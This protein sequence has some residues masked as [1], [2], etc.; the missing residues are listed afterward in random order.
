MFDILDELSSQRAQ[1]GTERPNHRAEL[2]KI[3]KSPERP[4]TPPPSDQSDRGTAHR[5][6]PASPDGMHTP[7]R[8][9]M[10]VSTPTGNRSPIPMNLDTPRRCPESRAPRRSR[11]RRNRIAYSPRPLGMP[12]TNRMVVK[13]HLVIRGMTGLLHLP[14]KNVHTNLEIDIQ[15]QESGA[16]NVR[17]LITACRQKA[18]RIPSLR[19][20]FQIFRDTDLAGW[21]LRYRPIQSSPTK[22]TRTWTTITEERPVSMFH[23]LFQA[24]AHHT[25]TDVVVT[26]SLRAQTRTKEETQQ[27][28]EETYKDPSTVQTG[29]QQS[30]APSL[31]SFGTPA[32]L[33]GYPMMIPGIHN[34]FTPHLFGTMPIPT[35]QTQGE[36]TTSFT[37]LREKLRGKLTTTPSLQS[38]TSTSTCPSDSS[39]QTPSGTSPMDSQED[40]NPQGTNP[41]TSPSPRTR[42]APSQQSWL[43]NGIHGNAP[44]T[45][46][47]NWIPTTATGS[48]PTHHLPTTMETGNLR[49]SALTG[50]TA[51]GT[52]GHYPYH[53]LQWGNR[54]TTIM[55]HQ[56]AFPPPTLTRLD[57]QGQANPGHEDT[58]F[59]PFL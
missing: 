23:P 35:S 47:T 57:N 34:P 52:T 40:S 25:M 43:F 56:F 27:Q 1:S 11:A 38:C 2:D 30:Q 46:W 7:P 58:R 3:L 14:I 12:S 16:V 42:D 28:Q 32:S 54:M 49:L 6:R 15:E 26:T 48:T 31:G 8:K 45:T 37:D 20:L 53:P 9:R 55:P 50:P 5:R 10:E 18:K 19:N 33:M 4:D 39:A 51:P 24:G 29:S 22:A 17:N 36:E 41:R 59:R 44:A 13:I 21:R